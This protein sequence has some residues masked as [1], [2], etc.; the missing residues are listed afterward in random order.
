VRLAWNPTPNWSLQA[1]WAD[2]KSPEQLEPDEDQEKWSASA[3]H[4]R[5]FGEAG[6]WSTTAAWG[7]RSGGH[8]SFD[9][10]I[11]ESSIKPNEAW[12]VFARAER[13]ENNELSTIGG[14]HGPTY[15]VAKAS[16]GAV[17]DWRLSRHLKFGV[18]ALYAVNFVPSGL[19]PAYGG[20]PN[21]AM[22]FVRLRIE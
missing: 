22:A 11:L 20:D 8:E 5:R 14:H 12:T 15:K 7:R 17:R 13:T 2:V 4:T 16:I 6:W 19:E 9:A 1:S 21:G 10:W 18:G 3:I